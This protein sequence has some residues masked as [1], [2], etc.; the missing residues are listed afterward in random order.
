MEH[1][2][3]ATDLGVSVPLHTAME[4]VVSALDSAG[5]VVVLTGAGISTDSG[6]PDF[7]GP[8][9]L[10]TK[11]PDAEKYSTIE[12]YL[13]DPE[14]RERAWRYR[15]SNPAFGAEPN[16]GH[17]ALVEL[18]R[19]GRLDLLV[20]QNVDGLHLAAGSDPS[21][22]VE[23]HGNMRSVECTSCEYRA[24]MD[25]AR[26][27]V[28]AGE[29]D[30]ACPI[31]GG[32]LKTAVVYFGESLDPDDLERAFAAARACDL[33]LCIGSTLEVHPI[34][35]MVPLALGAGA[36][37]VVINR[38]PTPFDAD[39]LALRTSIGEVLPP[40]VREVSRT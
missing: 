36:R 35:H 31:C 20:T 26:R 13:A 30:P 4:L 18:E 25:V 29:S 37:L 10:W 6:I 15:L 33:L 38:D 3:S 23:V 11:D 22:L 9:G 21:R 7:R 39:A 1:E 27:R 24:P 28:E 34:A 2:P 12:H 19:A 5:R 16:S 14:L 17:R 32:I 8:D 40:I